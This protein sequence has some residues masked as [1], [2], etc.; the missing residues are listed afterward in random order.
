MSF[1]KLLVALFSLGGILFTYWFFLMKKE[2]VVLIT[3]SSS[4]IGQE[5]AYEFARAG[6]AVII[7]YLFP[8]NKML[9]T[10][11]NGRSKTLKVFSYWF[12]S[13]CISKKH[14]VN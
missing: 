2:Q 4:G 7:T 14:F 11:I 13:S 6:Y 9:H 8:K 1:D 10:L 3:G 5:T 12:N